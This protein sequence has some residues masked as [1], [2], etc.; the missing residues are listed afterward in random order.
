[1]VSVSRF[2]ENKAVEK[3]CLSLFSDLPPADEVPSLAVLS[4]TSPVPQEGQNVCDPDQ[5]YVPHSLPR[6]HYLS[7]VSL[8]KIDKSGSLF[9]RQKS[10]SL[11]S[12]VPL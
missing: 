6:L 12:Q 7:V 4:T 8:P 5:D 11:P 9:A 10:P 3:K 1:M 2:I